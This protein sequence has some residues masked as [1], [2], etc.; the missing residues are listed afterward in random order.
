VHRSTVSRTAIARNI[1][2]VN[3]AATLDPVRSAA[4]DSVAGAILRAAVT[5]R[6]C[7][8]GLVAAV[9]GTDR[10]FARVVDAIWADVRIADVGRSIGV[11]LRGREDGREASGDR[12]QNSAPHLVLLV[13]WF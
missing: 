2:V 9:R 1:T 3:S 5:G 10:G 12:H 7:T 8:A 11:D 4:F 13:K 6:R